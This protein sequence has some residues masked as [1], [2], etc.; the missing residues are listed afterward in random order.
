MLSPEALTAHSV[1][2]GMPRGKARGAAR[3]Y[4][5]VIILKEIF[6]RKPSDALLFLGGTALRLG[7]GLQRFS[8]DLDFD[9][10]GLSSRE[11]QRLL[12]EAAHALAGAGFEVSLKLREKGRLLAGEMRFGGFLQSYGVSASP[13]EKLMVKLEAN[14]PG[15]RMTAEPRVISGYGELFPARF[16]SPGLLFAEK[17]GALRERRQGRDIYDVFFMAGLKWRPDGAVL[18]A[19]GAGTDAAGAVVGRVRQWDTRDLA[20]M[21]RALDPFLFESSGASMVARAHELLP[22]ALAYLA[23]R[24]G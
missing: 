23:E 11:W 21:A 13:G 4:L 12:G 19:R 24:R 1:E 20:R 14:R 8:E 22:G 9:A 10:E 6:R 17:I 18:K 16:A 3:E 5:H 7:Y 15:W 2:R